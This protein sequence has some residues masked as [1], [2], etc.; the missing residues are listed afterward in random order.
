VKHGWIAT[1]LC[2][3]LAAVAFPHTLG[4]TDIIVARLAAATTS[5]NAVSVTLTI[6]NSNPGVTGLLIQSSETLDG[7]QWTRE[8]NTLTPSI[9]GTN[10]ATLPSSLSNRK[11]Y[12][13][14]GLSGTA[15]DRDG[16][17]LSDAF[18]ASIGTNS[19][20]PDSDGDGYM[21]GAEYAYGSDPKSPQ[22]TPAFTNLPRAEFAEAA[23]SANEGDGTSTVR[24][25]FDKPFNGILNYAVSSLS[26][27]RASVDYAPL[28]GSLLVNGL[29]AV[30]NI[31]LIDDINI[32]SPRAV[33]LEI[34]ADT[35]RTYSRGGLSRHTVS[36]P[37]NDAWWSCHLSDDNSERHLRLKLLRRG[38]D[39]HVVFAAGAGLDGLEIMGS[40]PANA[41]STR[42]DGLIPKGTWPG[43]VLLDLPSHFKVTSPLL[44][45]ATGGLFGSGTGLRRTLVLESQPSATGPR[46]FHQ[47]T[48]GRYVGTFTETLGLPNSN[49]LGATNTGAFVMIRDFPVKP[50]PNP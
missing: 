37:E 14:L 5:S 28:S 29:E 22:S 12:R 13:V 8:G 41:R 47:V 6:F 35:N 4:A 20:D 48:P 44:P 15:A 42:S 2:L 49:Y 9:S 17:G 26:P 24:I 46:Q 11:F 36:I 3:G 34:K 40:E 39:T 50:S 31:S 43:T 30:V 10:V 21:D 23:S 45:A 38:A 16:D 1:L 27:A 33:F 18:E 32:S 25:I 19:L 7:P